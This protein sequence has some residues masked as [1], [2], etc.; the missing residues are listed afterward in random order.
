MRMLDVGLDGGRMLSVCV[1]LFFIIFIVWFIGLFIEIVEDGG[2]DK[3]MIFFLGMK[4]VMRYM[5]CN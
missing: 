3:I 4:N 1:R 2:V 5:E